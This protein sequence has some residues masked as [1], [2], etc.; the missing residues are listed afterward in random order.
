MRIAVVIPCYNVEKYVEDAV[1]SV[2][3]QEGVEPDVVAVDDGS[4]DATP[5]ILEQLVAERPHHLRVLSQPNRGANAA[6]NA[7]LA[8]TSGEYVQFLDADDRLL[9]GKLARQAALAVR[10]GRPVMVVGAYRKC[11]PDGRTQEVL[12]SGDDAW[13]AW[14]GLQL[15][16]TSANLWQRE[17][18]QAAGGW[19]EDQA[20]SQDYELAHR[21][22]IHGGT[23]VM[24]DTL[25]TI[26]NR[27][28]HGSISAS[29]TV[30]N[31]E[32]YILLRARVKEHL[33]A[34]HSA[35]HVQLIAR[36]KQQMFMLI[37]VIHRHD[38][39]RAMH[40]LRSLFPEG[41]RPERSPGLSS[42][43]CLVHRLFGFERAERIAR[44]GSFSRRTVSIP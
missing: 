34:L 33:E 6:R 25:G 42:G 16:T 36:L 32:R 44:L 27:R 43:Y 30:G 2:W 41:Y 7:G 3:S 8:E 4:T 22:F 10:S 18:L 26:V 21:L 13:S 39:E 35:V 17:A 29:D 15:G 24:D 40:L 1:R 5:R 9:S 20:S 31:M 14:V 37:R 28:T 38:R 19:K 11:W 12:P 23:I